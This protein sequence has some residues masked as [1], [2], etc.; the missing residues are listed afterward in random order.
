MAETDAWVPV[1]V[2]MEMR[3]VTMQVPDADRLVMTEVRSADGH[4]L[5]RVGTVYVPEGAGRPLLVAFPADRQT[6]FVAPLFGARLDSGGLTLAYPADVVTGGPSV[7]AGAALSVGE[8]G[9]VLAY[10]QPGVRVDPR[11]PLTD[12][13]LGTGDVASGSPEVQ[14]VPAVPLVGDE[15]LPP[16]VVTRPGHSGPRE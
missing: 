16:I 9:A 14:L 6:P 10:Y 5:G 2:T 4:P 7:D 1:I 8:I 15:D 11:R 13:L 12:R 3:K